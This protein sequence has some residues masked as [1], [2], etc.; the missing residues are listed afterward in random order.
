MQAST[1]IAPAL[2]QGNSLKKVVFSPIFFLII[3]VF[4]LVPLALVR[5][6]PIPLGAMFWDQYL[7]IDAANRIA[8]GQVPG[9]DFF[10]PVG[11]LG[12]YLFAGLIKLFPNGAIL[13]LSNWSLLA[14]TAPLT[15]L[16]LFDAQKRSHATAWALLLPFLVFS[17]LPFNTGDFYPFPGTDGFGIYNRQ[18]CQLLYVLAAALCFLRAPALLGIVVALAM[19]TLLFVKVTGVVSGV[20]LCAMA[21]AA[22]RLPFRVALLSGLVFFL[23]IGLLEISSGIVSAYADDMIAL[24]VLNDTSLLPRLLQS[25]SINFGIIASAG[26]LAVALFVIDREKIS[27]DWTLFRSTPSATTV[28]HLLDQNWLWLAAFLLAGLLFESQNTGSQ[29]F[30][31]L[32][33]LVLAILIDVY[34]V[35]GSSPAFMVAGVLAMAA[36]LPPLVT[37]AQ[38]TARSTIG[39]VNDITLENRNLKTLGAVSLRPVF[40]TRAERMHVNYIAHR[41][42]YEEIARAGELPANLL[43]SDFDFYWLWLQ[44]IDDAIDALK[45]HETAGNVRFETMMSIDFTNPFPWLMDRQAP[46]AITIG[47]DPFR[48]VPPPN[49][50]VAK[51]V[52]AVDIALLPTCP[53]TT[54]RRALLGL[55]E[56]FLKDDHTRIQ[57][58]PC[59]DAFVRN[60]LMAK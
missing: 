55:Y 44:T 57:L 33:P 18:V 35:R 40:V 7:Y 25:A 51:A 8:G 47:A 9:V 36:M 32:W 21:F 39:S 56:P 19:L 12:Y 31:F 50:K 52:A 29:A 45:A 26:L 10:A 49:E 46:H 14:V 41:N 28:S 58:T 11:S 24:L 13:L 4:L 3:V 1:D 42:T 43:Y 2:G 60:A 53:P 37:I 54:A 59:Y 6:I 22:G 30:I 20:L 5:T 15:A 17:L 38:K 48:A 27:K 23:A 34:R 16:V